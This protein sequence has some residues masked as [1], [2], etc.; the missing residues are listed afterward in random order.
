MADTKTKLKIKFEDIERTIVENDE[1]VDDVV[2]VATQTAIIKQV[3]SEYSVA[4][5][6][7]QAKRKKNLARLKLYN[8]QMKEDKAVGDPL[9]FTVFNTVHASLYEDRL[10]NVWEGRGGRGDEDVESNLNAVSEYDYD[11]MQKPEIDYYW[12]WDAEFFGRG[13]LLNMDFDRSES[14]MCPIPENID[15]STFIRDP[16]AS[17]VNGNVAG[18]GSMRFGGWEVGATYYELKGLPGYFNLKLLR[19]TKDEPE[20]LLDE[21]RSAHRQAQGLEDFSNR[22]ESLGK[23]ENYEFRLLNWFTTIKGQKYLVTL[24]NAR[25]V[26]V[27]LV[28]LDYNGKWPINDR[29]LYP[30]A[31]NWDGVSIPDLTEDKQRGRAKLLNIAME[32]ATAEVTPSYLFDQT[33]IKNKNDLNLRI[34]KFIAVDGRVDNAMM[35][36]QKSTAHQFATL[37]MD[38]LDQSAQR[39]TAA[40]E[41]RQ[42]VQSKVGRTLGEQQMAIAGGDTRF[43]MSAKIYGWSDRAFWLQWYV[44]Y[45]K[46][47]KDGI[48]KKVVRI[49]GAMA[50]TW[51]EFTREN[52]ISTVDP[53]VRIESRIVSEY[54][55]Q[56]DRDSFSNFVSVA[57]QDPEVNKRFLEKRLAKLNGMSKEEIDLAFPP[58]VDE[59]Q[60]EDENKL[61]NNK[62][63][64]KIS[65][66]DDHMTH[67][68]IHSK[69][70]QNAWSL[71]HMQ[72]HKKLMVTKRDRTDLFPPKKGLQI[73]ETASQQTGAPV[74]E[75]ASAPVAAPA[76]IE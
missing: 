57:M 49:Q 36:V 43:G 71:A 52:L 61:L 68:D 21:L 9:M 29:A 12:N 11:L 72:A 63:L 46:H 55:K 41:L 6:F 59:I 2:D 24:G 51:R 66:M 7:N 14:R 67:I 8:N 58:T 26:L 69:A 13:L 54:K 4:Y 30:M 38:V 18:K 28:K 16:R 27:R 10:M 64:P 3:Q 47:F 37:I 48:D 50:P 34:N 31:S 53:D 44:L 15:A 56:R 22:E 39:A 65:V 45:K 20:D 40:T 74:V 73:K 19:K 25:S 60:A 1:V 33:R 70:N 23:Y 17:S 35:P 75:T 32:S 5:P 76:T 42:G 62:Q